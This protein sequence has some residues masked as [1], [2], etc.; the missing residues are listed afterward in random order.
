MATL[1]LR[2][3]ISEK[4]VKCLRQEA[5]NRQVSLDAVVGDVLTDYFDEPTEAEIL[6]SLRT[7]MQEALAGEGRPALEALDEIDREMTGDAND[8]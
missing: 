1:D 6:N 3:D 7:G 5:S 2:V 4:I 8:R